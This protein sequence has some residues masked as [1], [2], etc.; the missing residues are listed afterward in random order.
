[1]E[2]INKVIDK[3]FD[4]MDE[5]GGV[6]FIDSMIPNCMIDYTKKS[7]FEGKLYWKAINSLVSESEIQELEGYYN[8]KL[9]K[10]Y[11][12]FLQHRHFIEL[13]LGGYCIRFFKNLPNTFV[14]DTKI[15]I[16]NYY[17]NLIERNYLPFAALSDY[18]VLCF[19]ANV[20]KPDNEYPILSFDHEDE[21]GESESY[22]PDFESMF[23][24]FEENLDEWISNKRKMDSSH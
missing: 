11:K 19:D 14:E 22:S 4:F 5:I 1:M 2:K 7:E 18:G 16:E 12:E 13:E 10:S 6:T 9:P 8:H 23:Q 17:W 24:E 20:S 21:F 15:E 3:Y